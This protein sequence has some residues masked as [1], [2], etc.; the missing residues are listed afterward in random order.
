E[1]RFL[2]GQRAAVRVTH[3]SLP[4]F[5]DI[6]RDPA[7]GAYAIAEVVGGPSLAEVI[8]RKQIP[9]GQ[10][11]GWFVS[12][13]DALAVAHARG[14]SHGALVSGGT[15]LLRDDSVMLIGLGLPREHSAAA[16]GQG[17]DL[18]AVTL[19]LYRALTGSLPEGNPPAAPSTLRPAVP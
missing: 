5:H 19:L 9:I 7:F 12:L 1:R 4:E 10:A 16:E 13:L 14:V 15:V 17:A 18:R 11:V 2:A 6:G 3:P 8:E